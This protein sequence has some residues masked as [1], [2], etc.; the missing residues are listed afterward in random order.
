MPSSALPLNL[1]ADFAT[2]TVPDIFAP[3]RITS[4]P[5]TTMGAASDAS[6]RSPTLPSLELTDWSTVTVIVVPGLIT[7]GGSGAGTAA[8]SAALAELALPPAL[9]VLP[10]FCAEPHP[11]DAS[12]ATAQ[13]HGES[14][15]CCI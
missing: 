8:C 14:L 4:L 10:L 6:T 5:S 13:I 3:G 1:P 15:S 7:I 12:K 9:P 11:Y 2:V